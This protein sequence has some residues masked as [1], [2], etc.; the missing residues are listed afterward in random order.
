MYSTHHTHKPRLLGRFIL[1]IEQRLSRQHANQLAQLSFQKQTQQAIRQMKEL[2]EVADNAEEVL[3]EA[4]SV[5]PFNIFPDSIKI[6]RQ[7]VIMIHREFFRVAS[8]QNIQLSKIQ[9][10][11]ADV[12]PFFGS[13]SIT[14]EQFENTVST[15][16]FLTRRDT[17]RVQELLQGFVVANQ[18]NIDYSHVD[19]K[20]LVPLI[21]KLGRGDTS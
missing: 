21:K 16:H 9:S 17:I 2:V 1:Y 14:A 4:T 5:F 13:V 15:I 8:I 18:R 12:G 6:D 11:E 3:L 10:I 7:K 19:T 20:E